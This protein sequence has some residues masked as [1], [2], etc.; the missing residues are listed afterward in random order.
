MKNCLDILTFMTNV[1]Y[2]IIFFWI[3]RMFLPL[4]K[5]W[6]LKIA[7]FVANHYLAS[8]VIY[9]SDLAGLL[10]TLLGF[11]VYIIVFYRGRWIEKLTTVLI[12]YPPL[13]AV[14]YLTMNIG[15]RCFFG[16]TGAPSE[17]E[18][19]WTGEQYLISDVIWGASLLLRLLF[20]LAAWQ[21]LRKYLRQI[22]SRLTTKMWLIVDALML[23]SFVAIFTIIYFM[24]ED[25]ISVYPIC[26]ASVFTSFGCIYLVS[27]ICNSMQTAYRVQ[28]LEMR[29]AYYTDRMRDEER[30]RRIYHDLKNHLLVLGA[31][32]GKEQVVWESIQGLQNQIQEYENYYHTGNAFLDVLIRDK[33]KTAQKEQIDFGV[34]VDFEGGDFIEPLD[35]STIFGNAIDNAIEASRK[36]PHEQ[37]LITVRANR[38]RDMLM[39]IVENTVSSDCGGS[40]RTTKEDTFLH[41]FGLSNIKN[42]VQKYDG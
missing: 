21:F 20:W 41:G 1:C 2:T 25:T 32:A 37:R 23:A 4:R 7:A 12:F 34:V 24:P 5:N 29:Q 38:V 8:A 19:G 36:L 35:I 39:I 14:N 26:G 17:P 18:F 33:A 27:Y 28:E 13:I 3:L 22:T 16:M 10:G 40:R 42:A 9:S 11:C 15:E 6:L 31:Y 30:V